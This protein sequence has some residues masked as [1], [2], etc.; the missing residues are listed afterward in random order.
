MITAI[1]SKWQQSYVV[2]GEGDDIILLYGLFGSVKNFDPLVRH[3]KNNYRVIVPVFPF[4]EMEHA[5]DIF[6]LT[7]FL[8]DLVE[9]LGLESFHL[10]GNSMG[11]HIGLLYALQYPHKVKSL[12]LSGSSGLFET[13]MGDSFPRRKD[14]AYIKEK[15]ER[16]FYDPAIASKELVDEIFETVNS[17]K[18]VL[19]II[20]LAKSTL[21]NNV[22]RQLGNIT[23]DCCL[24]W[25]REDSI[26][27]PEVAREFKKHIPHARL[28]WI[29]HCG[30]VPMLEQPE[31]FNSVLDSFFLSIY[32]KKISNH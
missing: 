18:K 12:I 11:G 3:L 20:S 21:R 17:R 4:Y 5:A 29:E 6:S 24:I 2:E 1:K 32:Q 28:F 14:Y 25:G 22:E 15:T 23:M 8:H 9:E 31:K 7:E 13:G 27:P 10:L 16:T 19:Q 30:H 26:T